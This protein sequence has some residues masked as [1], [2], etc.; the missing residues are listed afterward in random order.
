MGIKNDVVNWDKYFNEWNKYSEFNKFLNSN[1]MFSILKFLSQ[2]YRRTTVFPAKNEIFK[3]FKMCDPHDLKV[4]IVG[5][6]P[7]LNGKGTGLAF[8]NKDTET[9]ISPELVAI[10][11][12]VEKD[13]NTI[14]LDFDVTLEK[15]AKQGV[16][17][18][19][20]SLTVRQNISHSHKEMWDKF[21][22]FV[23][24]FIGSRFP[25]T[26]IMLW[27]AEAQRYQN[28]DGFELKSTCYIYRYSHPK[29]NID[30]MIDWNCKHFSMV[31][32]L[33]EQQNG[34]EEC[35]KW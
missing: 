23:L 14:K 15:W 20:T 34:K 35:I 28:V 7:Y 5:L 8:A 32:L 27:G 18:L 21:T 13:V 16:L 33:L 2:E 26:H 25:G 1:Y 9:T 12:A 10:R 31:N 24:H 3:A 4:V 19:N 29:Y 30:K 11:N 22:K 17:L 6:E